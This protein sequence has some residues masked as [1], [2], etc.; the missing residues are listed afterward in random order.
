MSG[1]SQKVKTADFSA[2][3]GEM[4]WI[5]CAAIG[6]FLKSLK[7]ARL[8]K[9]ADYQQRLINIANFEANM[10]KSA[11]T[12]NLFIQTM[13]QHIATKPI[14]FVAKNMVLPVV[15][16]IQNM[17]KNVLNALAQFSNKLA[18][19]SDKL[20]AVYGE[21]KASVNKKIS[22]LKKKIKK[23]L[24]SIFTIFEAGNDSDENEMMVAFEKQIKK[25]KNF[26]EKITNRDEKEELEDDN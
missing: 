2:K 6:A 17:P 8:A 10:A 23:K 4:S 18:D 11:E 22:D 26:L 7:N 9:E 21:L 25:L 12:L 14:A 5:E 13:S 24:F 20:A 19:I 15:K 1:G 16:F 3:P